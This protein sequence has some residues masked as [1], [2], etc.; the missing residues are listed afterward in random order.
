MFSSPLIFCPKCDKKIISKSRKKLSCDS[1]ELVPCLFSS[2]EPTEFLRI[3]GYQNNCLNYCF[4]KLE[5]RLS[6]LYNK[7]IF[8][9]RKF[10]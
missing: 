1:G 5:A 7:A 3:F 2:N 10:K 9:L 6:D 8:F 4:Q